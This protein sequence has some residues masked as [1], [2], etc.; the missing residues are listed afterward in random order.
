[1]AVRMGQDGSQ[2]RKLLDLTG[3]GGSG[4]AWGGGGL[5]DIKRSELEL[6]I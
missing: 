4:A 3:V 6:F 1:M 2:E 5:N